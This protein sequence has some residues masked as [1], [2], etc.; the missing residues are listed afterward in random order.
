MKQI[1]QDITI[2]KT[3]KWENNARNREEFLIRPRPKKGCRAYDDEVV[4]F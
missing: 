2:V 3:K 4:L 1:E